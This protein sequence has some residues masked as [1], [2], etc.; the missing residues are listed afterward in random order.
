MFWAV[1]ELCVLEL[2]WWKNRGGVE[3][4]QI[5]SLLMPRLSCVSRFLINPH[6]RCKASVH[7][8]KLRSI[9]SCVMRSTA[10]TGGSLQLNEWYSGHFHKQCQEMVK[11]DRWGTTSGVSLITDDSLW[12][13]RRKT[14]RVWTSF[15]LCYQG[16][17]K[18]TQ[19]DVIICCW[20]YGGSKNSFPP[21]SAE[22][23]RWEKF[24]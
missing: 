4:D 22:K 17:K 11:G 20:K 3:N 19:S 18:M 7:P 24:N 21:V 12:E 6:R 10:G 16:Q 14:E 1:T 13:R 2:T 23:F 5:S 8:M 9:S 15:C